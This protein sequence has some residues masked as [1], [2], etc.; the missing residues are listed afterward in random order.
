MIDG[1]HRIHVLRE[2]GVDVD[3]LAREVLIECPCQRLEGE[4]PRGPAQRLSET[5]AAPGAD[6]C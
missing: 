2:R 6:L 3:A 5:A 1:H 4:A